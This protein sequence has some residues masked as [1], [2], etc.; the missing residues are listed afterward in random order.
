MTLSNLERWDAM[1]Q[2]FDPGDLLHFI[3][4]TQLLTTSI[5]TTGIIYLASSFSRLTTDSN[6]DT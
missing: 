5:S 1:G 6:S 2:I 3:L 4:F